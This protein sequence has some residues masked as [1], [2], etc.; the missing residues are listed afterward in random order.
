[1]IDSE[2]VFIEP[3]H[4]SGGIQSIVGDARYDDDSFFI[5]SGSQRNLLVHAVPYRVRYSFKTLPQ[6][7][8]TKEHL[9]RLLIR[10]PGWDNVP[11]NLE[12]KGLN[13]L[14]DQTEGLSLR[15]IPE[16]PANAIY[17]LGS[18]Q[19]NPQQVQ[20]IYPLSQ[21]TG[22]YLRRYFVGQWHQPRKV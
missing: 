22:R 2:S 1:M 21:I 3:L 5:K 17:S 7:T 13:E 8:P 19:E 10:W 20:T 9:D 14:V 6:F 4:S 16:D 12:R 15:V 18:L 11:R